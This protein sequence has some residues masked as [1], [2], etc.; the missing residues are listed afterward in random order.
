MIRIR[1]PQQP[2]IL[3]TLV[4]RIYHAR[5]CSVQSAGAASNRIASQV[6]K[7]LEKNGAI[8]GASAVKRRLVWLPAQSASN[9]SGKSLGLELV[10]SKHAQYPFACQ[11]PSTDILFVITV[12]GDRIHEGAHTRR[13]NVHHGVV[14][15]HTDRHVRMTKKCRKVGRVAPE[16][17]VV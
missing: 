6:E 8:L 4:I 7:F 15:R 9:L 14:S 17:H 12:P 16:R 11:L 13:K 1:Y 10:F 2:I 5:S 3:S